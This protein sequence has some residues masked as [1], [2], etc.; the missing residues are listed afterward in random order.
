M[1]GREHMPEGLQDG[2]WGTGRSR[3][4][5]QALRTPREEIWG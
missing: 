4:T 1:T 5:Q 2:V 3:R